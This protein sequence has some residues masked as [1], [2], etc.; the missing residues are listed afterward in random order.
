M[1]MKLMTL[2]SPVLAGAVII[3]SAADALGQSQ[4]PGIKV[5]CEMR[6]GIPTTMATASQAR[7]LAVFH[8][9]ADTWFHNKDAQ[10]LCE[11]VSQK[12]QRYYDGGGQGSSFNVHETAIGKQAICVESKPGESC[13]RMLFTL[14]SN[15]SQ[16]ESQKILDSILD[17]NLKTTSDDRGRERG[18]D[19]RRI[20]NVSLWALLFPR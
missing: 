16:E 19:H 10:T 2:W 7:S 11:D 1:K 14:A 9:Q 20:N 6:N 12:L 18:G 15:Y 13:S 3:M 8:W 4:S 5:T 17:S